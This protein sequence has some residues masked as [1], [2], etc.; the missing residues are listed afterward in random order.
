[1]VTEW[2][3]GE[4]LVWIDISFDHDFRIGGHLER[5]GDTIDEFN[6]CSPQVTSQKL[7]IKVRW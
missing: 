6:G 7:F 5:L 1:M 2:S 3:F 4:V